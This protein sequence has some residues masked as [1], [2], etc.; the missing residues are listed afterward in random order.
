MLSRELEAAKE[1]L[2]A[3]EA[4]RDAKVMTRNQPRSAPAEIM[5]TTA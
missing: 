5:R 2:A 4:H 3:L 1:T